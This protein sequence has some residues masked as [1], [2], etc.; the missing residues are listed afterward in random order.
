MFQPIRVLQ[1][2]KDDFF[3]VEQAKDMSSDAKYPFWYIR[4]RRTHCLII[5]TKIISCT[6]KINSPNIG[7]NTRMY[8][9]MFNAFHWHTGKNVNFK[10]SDHV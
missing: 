6:T 10:M 7:I 8:H 9:E 3:F 4:V 5:F 2:W 1:I